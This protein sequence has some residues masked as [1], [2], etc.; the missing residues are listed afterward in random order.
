MFFILL[1]C[2][3]IKMESKF[4]NYFYN[5]F[6]KCGEDELYDLVIDLYKTYISKSNYE[7]RKEILERIEL[8]FLVLEQTI[9]DIKNKIN[10]NDYPYL[11][12]SIKFFLAESIHQDYGLLY[13]S[14]FDEINYKLN[15][16]FDWE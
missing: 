2:V 12:E 4:E 3:V 11:K 10:E 7:I 9:K 1:I 15:N 13:D 16:Y 5:I 6:N 14:E 8:L